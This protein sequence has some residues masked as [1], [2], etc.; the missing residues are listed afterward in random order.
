MNDIYHCAYFQIYFSI[1][2][3][4]FEIQLKKQF[5]E[6]F[7]SA[8]NMLIEFGEVIEFQISESSMKKWH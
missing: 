1:Y 7:H 8:N 6:F 3:I 2:E 4:F 5:F